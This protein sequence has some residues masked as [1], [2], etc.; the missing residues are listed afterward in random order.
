MKC[1][2]VLPVDPRIRHQRKATTVLHGLQFLGATTSVSFGSVIILEF[3][4]ILGDLPSALAGAQ[5]KIIGWTY[6]DKV[7]VVDVKVHEEVYR[8]ILPSYR[9]ELA[10]SVPE[11][12]S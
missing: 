9:R 10:L 3:A 12:C 1:S 4:L 2:L 6:Q 11:R 5:P 8:P 7:E